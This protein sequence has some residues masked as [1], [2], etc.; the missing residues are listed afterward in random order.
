[1]ALVQ[2]TVTLGGTGAGQAVQC[3]ATRTPFYYMRIESD[4]GNAIA[5]YGT[6]VLTTTD[7]A[8]TV[9]ADTATVNNAVIIGAFQAVISNA[10]EFWF[11]GT[12]SQKLRV[13]LIT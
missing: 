2:L 1:M 4:I 3:T 13:T 8:G 5:Y 6:S 12:N 7:Y 10:D 9:L 11:L